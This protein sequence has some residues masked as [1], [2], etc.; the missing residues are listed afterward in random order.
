MQSNLYCFKRLCKDF[1]KPFAQ[2]DLS[3]PKKIFN[4]RLSRARNVVEN[5]FGILASRFRIYHTEINMQIKNIESV[6]LATCALHNFLRQK[7]K[8][9]LGFNY[10]DIEDAF[11][12]EEE[13]GFTNLKRGQNRHASDQG[14]EV[15]NAFLEYFITDGKVSWQENAIK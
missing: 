15:R 11:I 14:K 7:S 5:A 13:H 9:Y 2:R 1:L 3:T 8:D 12:Y 6:V 4:Y 10:T